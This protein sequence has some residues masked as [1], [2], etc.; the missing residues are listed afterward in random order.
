MFRKLFW[1]F[2]FQASTKLRREITS[3]KP[4][5]NHARTMK[6]SCQK[7]LCFSTSL[8]SYFYQNLGGFGTPNGG[9]NRSFGHP[10]NYCVPF[11]GFGNLIGFHKALQNLPRSILEPPGV[12]FGAPGSRFGGVRTD[13]WRYLPVIFLARSSSSIHQATRTTKTFRTSNRLPRNV[14]YRKGGGGAPPPRGIQ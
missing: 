3:K 1:K 8:F 5:K 9:Q 13:F 2:I 11:L 10:T 6:K 7:T 14:K 4:A 12:D